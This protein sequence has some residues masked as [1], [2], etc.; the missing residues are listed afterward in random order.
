MNDQ[1]IIL[2]GGIAGLSAADYAR[3]LGHIFPIYEASPRAGGL[4]DSFQLETPQGTW[5]FDNGVHLA[6]GNEPEVR[7]IFD[8]THSISHEAKSLNWD[9]GYWL[10][11]PVQNNMYPLPA[12]QKADL[13]A[14]LAEHLAAG[15]AAA[16]A[17]EINTYRDWL[18][19]QYGD[20][21]AER[22]PLQYTR[23]YWTV[24]AAELGTS[25]VG[26]RMRRA[27]LREVLLGA[28]SPDAPNTY[29][30]SSMRYPEQGGYRS[31]IL[32]LL[33]N[34]VLHS[35]HRAT[36]LD[37]RSRTISFENGHHVS[38][39]QLIATIPLPQ[40]I[41]IMTDVPDEIRAAAQTLFASAIDLVS[42]GF[43]RPSVSPSLWF[44][45][46]DP[47]ILAA[48]V[49]SPS[50]KSPANSPA[51]HSSVQFEIYSSSRAPQTASVEDLKE[52]CVRALEKLNLVR[53]DEIVLL[54]HKHIPYGNVVFDLGME[55]RRDKVRAWVHT[56]NVHLAGR[57]GEWEYLWSNQSLMSGRKAA[58]SAVC[59][60]SMR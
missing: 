15:A 24:D 22:W 41:A 2:G 20:K 52:N 39:E 5:T 59:A 8:R 18:L 44:Y 31:F 47:D 54:H 29:Y 34:A 23:K 9:N 57:F 38:Y 16:G 55:Q 17:P 35:G 1:T 7:E 45:I 13:I 10:S 30:I 48:R 37:N 42:I 40:L 3:Q 53:R 4:L 43:N 46:Y 28:M 19:H 21:I 11:H 49:Y 33:E 14:D 51:G 60:A 36:K 56:Q 32:P 12:D 25:W 27:N 26:S 58:Q 50:R 6:F